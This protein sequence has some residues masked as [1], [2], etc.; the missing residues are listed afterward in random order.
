MNDVKIRYLISDNQLVIEKRRLQFLIL[1]IST[2]F[3][4][5]AT[6]LRNKNISF[7]TDGVE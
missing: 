6:R 2:C 1:R 3:A 7:A 4:A 5:G